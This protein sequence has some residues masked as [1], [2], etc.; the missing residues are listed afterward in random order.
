MEP[1]IVISHN[2]AV[3]APL[4]VAMKRLA[5]KNRSASAF[6]LISIPPHP[7]KPI[8]I[9]GPIFSVCPMVFVCR[10]HLS[11]GFAN[12]PAAMMATVEAATSAAQPES[13]E[14]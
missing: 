8:W 9:V 11:A 12:V 14:Q 6:S 13:M 7:V 10:E 3:T 2:R 1:G 5:L 4:R